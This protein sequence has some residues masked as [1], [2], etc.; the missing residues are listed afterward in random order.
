MGPNLRVKE[1]VLG[2]GERRERHAV[3]H[4]PREARRRRT[5][6][7]GVLAEL[8]AKL[9]ALSSSEHSKKVCELR[10]SRRYGRYFRL[11]RGGKLRI[12]QTG[13]KA[14][15]RLDGKFVVHT[16]DD[17]LSADDMALSY[18]QLQRVE[19]AWRQMKSGLGLRPIH[20]RAERRIRAHVAL[21]VLALFL[22]QIAEQMVGD[23]WRNIRHDLAGIKLVELL[24]PNGTIRQVTE[25]RPS[26]AKR[27]KALQI[28]PPPPILRVG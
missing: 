18:R 10:S 5:H 16:N 2:D 26:A 15:E 3:C 25:P 23:T 1:V 4:N 27:L 14:A 19:Q 24:G 20:H 21:T 17:T 9:G 13:V 22:E 12:N 11:T 7:A 28:A 6:R 8:E